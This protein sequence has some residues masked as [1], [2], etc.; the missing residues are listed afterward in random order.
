MKIARETFRFDAQRVKVSVPALFQQTRGRQ[1]R[2]FLPAATTLV[3][4]P[5]PSI[6]TVAFGFGHASARSRFLR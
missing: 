2:R 1:T 6:Y 4:V 5:L 3:F